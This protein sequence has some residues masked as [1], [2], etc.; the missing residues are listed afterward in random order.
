MD[1]V[2]IYILSEQLGIFLEAELS[3]ATQQ[4]IVL[5][6]WWLPRVFWLWGLK[7]GDAL[8]YDGVVEP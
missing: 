2:A 3:Q 1:T 8:A 7:V 4:M 6:L 5:S